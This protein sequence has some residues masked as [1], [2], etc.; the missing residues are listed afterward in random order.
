MSILPASG[1]FVRVLQRR[2]DGPW[3]SLERPGVFLKDAA[4]FH[5]SLAQGQ[6]PMFICHVK[7]VQDAP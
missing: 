7:R 2:T 5:V 4:G 1:R 6:G 3:Y